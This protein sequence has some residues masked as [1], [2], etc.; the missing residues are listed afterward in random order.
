[1]PTRLKAAAEARPPI[2]APT[3]AIDKG[4]VIALRPPTPLRCDNYVHC[5]LSLPSLKRKHPGSK[6]D[7]QKPDMLC[8]T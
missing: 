7:T 8:G 3:M 4:L 5:R 1:M 6:P 2:P